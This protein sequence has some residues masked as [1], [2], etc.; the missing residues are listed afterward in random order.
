MD[1]A[2]GCFVDRMQVCRN[3]HVVTDRLASCPEH[4]TGHC[5]RC[6]ATT[7]DRCP[8]C[9]TVLIVTH[10]PGLFPLAAP[11]PPQYCAD[12]GAAFP[13]VRPPARL[14]QAL[15]ALEH[16]LRRLPHVIRGLRSRH[17]DRPPF[18]VRDHFDLEDLL[19]ALLPLHFHDCRPEQRTPTYAIGQ[20][21]DFILASVQVAV[22]IKHLPADG[23]L[24][25][26]WPEDLRYYRLQRPCSTVVGF[27]YDPQGQLPDAPYS[28]RLWSQSGREPALRCVIAV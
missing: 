15:E 22:L 11:R 10:L 3:G 1:T 17:A 18:Q 21:T 24:G 12:C 23:D 28:E 26:H 25:A 20:R 14:S 2:D 9:G 13:W 19:R 5:D 7:V 8:T 27:V 4:G 16:L 6:G